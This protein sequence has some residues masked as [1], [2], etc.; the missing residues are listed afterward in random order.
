MAAVVLDVVSVATAEIV[1]RQT[2][3]DQDQ[4]LHEP[5]LIDGGYAL[6][7]T[8]TRKEALML[9]RTYSCSQTHGDEEEDAP[10]DVGVQ[11]L[12]QLA[13]LVPRPAVV[14][15]GFGLMT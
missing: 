7:F 15:H 5:G 11:T 14:H 2:R 8:E 10:Q 13:A 12:L 4:I 9:V 6:S 3:Q 1:D